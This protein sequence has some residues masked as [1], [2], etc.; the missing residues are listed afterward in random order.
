M[1]R[2]TFKP[3]FH[4]AI[5][6]GRKT[7]TIREKSKHLL[8][9]DQVAAVGHFLTKAADRFARLEI[10]HTK[11]FFWKDRTP[12]MLAKTN[13]TEEWYQAHIPMLNDMKVLHYYEFEVI[14][15]EAS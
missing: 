14:P 15:E 9:G 4:D 7:A 11:V 12:E 5:R 3:E 8:Q 2:L 6:D 10:L 13:A 1:K